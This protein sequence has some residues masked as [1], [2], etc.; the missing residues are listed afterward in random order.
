MRAGSSHLRRRPRTQCCG[1][2]VRGA[3][4]CSYRSERHFTLAWSLL[5]GRPGEVWS[6][7]VVRG[8]GEVEAVPSKQALTLAE[9]NEL[10][11]I[12]GGGGVHGSPWGASLDGS[13]PTCSTGRCP[14]PP[15]VRCTAWCWTSR[16]KRSTKRRR[17]GCGRVCATRTWAMARS[18]IVDSGMSGRRPETGGSSVQRVGRAGQCPGGSDERDAGGVSAGL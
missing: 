13:W 14:P 18:G 9:G 2:V 11:I 10:W 15:P 16:R 6:T 8:S 17:K 7:E 12:S 3:I 1:E 4:T 5:G